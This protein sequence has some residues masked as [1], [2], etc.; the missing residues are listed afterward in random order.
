MLDTT[1]VVMIVDQRLYKQMSQKKFSSANFEPFIRHEL[2]F[3]NF[4]VIHNIL[5]LSFCTR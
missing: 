4:I 3:E 2:Y 5:P 1:I